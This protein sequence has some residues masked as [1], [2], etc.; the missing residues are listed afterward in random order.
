MIYVYLGHIIAKKNFEIIKSKVF[1]AK[2]RCFLMFF[3]IY[4]KRDFGI[5]WV[6]SNAFS[7]VTVEDFRKIFSRRESQQKNPETN[8]AGFLKFLKKCRF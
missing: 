7:R 2:K 4:S 6:Q 1:R 8:E 3:A 5:G